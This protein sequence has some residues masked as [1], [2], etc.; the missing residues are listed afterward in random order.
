MLAEIGI[1]IQSNQF[2]FIEQKG[3]HGQRKVFP[4]LLVFSS[5]A[6]F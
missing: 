6:L 3:K 5:T 4:A 1:E 2:Y